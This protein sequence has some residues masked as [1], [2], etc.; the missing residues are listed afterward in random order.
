M[1]PDI[2]I[3]RPEQALERWL[4]RQATQGVPELVLV[5][6]LR[7]AADDIEECGYISREER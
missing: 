3:G 7:E 4:V 5:S 2:E 6:L 1:D